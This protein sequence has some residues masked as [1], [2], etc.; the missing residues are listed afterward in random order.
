M[1]RWWCGQ[2]EV[3]AVNLAYKQ[4]LQCHQLQYACAA[5]HTRTPNDDI[6]PYIDGPSY[7]H[8]K[9]SGH[10]SHKGTITAARVHA[11]ADAARG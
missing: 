8:A 11:E 10:P 5:L 7:K 9:I 3:C 4:Q 1:V 2:Q 6:L